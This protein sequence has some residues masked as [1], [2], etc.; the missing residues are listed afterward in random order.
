MHFLSFTACVLHSFSVQVTAFA[1]GMS[2][3]R[4]IKLWSPEDLW[5]WPGA[6]HIASSTADFV[7]TC[8]NFLLKIN[9]ILSSC[10]LFFDVGVWQRV[11]VYMSG[12]AIVLARNIWVIRVIEPL[13]ASTGRAGFDREDDE[14]LRTEYVGTRW[15]RAPEARG[16]RMLILS[17]KFELLVGGEKNREWDRI[18]IYIY[19]IFIVIYNWLQVPRNHS[20]TCWNLR[21]FLSHRIPTGQRWCSP[22]RN[23][24]LPLICGA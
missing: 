1:N 21:R 14:W 15:Y 12:C 8:L 10:R 5:L 16:E 7:S 6:R 18:Y 20:Q 17:G 3:Q 19:I 22:P 23:T 24:Q 13:V 11:C 9:H 2:S 4:S